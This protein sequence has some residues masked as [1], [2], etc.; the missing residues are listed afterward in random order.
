MRDAL[1]I[2]RPCYA[3]AY[4]LTMCFCS[5][6]WKRFPTHRSQPHLSA[7]FFCTGCSIYVLPARQ[8][9]VTNFRIATV[10]Q[11]NPQFFKFAEF[12]SVCSDTE[13]FCLKIFESVLSHSRQ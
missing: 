10:Q 5:Y 9:V 4:L 1:P 13:H 3:V 12:F 2:V 7:G 8:D 6:V 11:Q